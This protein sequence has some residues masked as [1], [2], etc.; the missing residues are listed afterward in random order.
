MCSFPE[1]FQFNFENSRQSLREYQQNIYL[2]FKSHLLFHGY[3]GS[4]C[5]QAGQ[6]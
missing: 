4:S 5:T 1:V 2:Y 3:H 6:L